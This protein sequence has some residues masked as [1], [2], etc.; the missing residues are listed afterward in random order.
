MEFTV[1][2]EPDCLMKHRNERM[3]TRCMLWC[4]LCRKLLG[5]RAETRELAR[6]GLSRSDILAY[7]QWD[8]KD[9][10]IRKVW[11][12]RTCAKFLMGALRPERRLV[13]LEHGE[14]GRASCARGC[15]MRETAGLIP[16]D[17]QATSHAACNHPAWLFPT[18]GG[19][20]LTSA[21][22]RASRW[23]QHMQFPPSIL[24]LQPILQE[25]EGEGLQQGM[26]YNLRCC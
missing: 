16:S 12:R 5:S 2:W 10:A 9:L 26:V 4:V 3:N 17:C 13:E 11:E 18:V 8:I 6:E 14:R 7:S 20:C 24:V 15:R 19:L 23:D 1:R 25:T 22:H 21:S